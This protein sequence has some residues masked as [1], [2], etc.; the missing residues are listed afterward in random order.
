LKI[1]CLTSFE[2]QQKNRKL[3]IFLSK[4][5]KSI[6]KLCCRRKSSIRT[7]VAAE[8]TIK[9]PNT[10]YIIRTSI[11]S[12]RPA[13]KMIN[14]KIETKKKTTVSF[15][16]NF[17]F[18]CFC[19]SIKRRITHGSCLVFYAF[20]KN[21]YIHKYFHNFQSERTNMVYPFCL[22]DFVLSVVIAKSEMFLSPI[23]LPSIIFSP[24]IIRSAFFWNN[25]IN[26][27]VRIVKCRNTFISNA[28]LLIWF[29]FSGLLVFRRTHQMPHHLAHLFVFTFVCQ[30]SDF[31]INLRRK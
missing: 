16:H 28:Y 3:I 2:Q 14:K 24:Q 30:K 1:Y 10:I 13:L 22:V 25:I 7:S 12:T 31:I 20:E 8:Q 27:S 29:Q 17:I 26:L 23:I 11:D 19:L 18:E 4:C 15:L 9:N 5:D 6:L 21:D